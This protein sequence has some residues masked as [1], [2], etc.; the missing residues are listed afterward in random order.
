MSYVIK[1]EGTTRIMATEYSGVN[2][3]VADA[4]DMALRTNTEVT[5]YELVPIK[6]FVRSDKLNV[7]EFKENET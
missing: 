6:S 2:A 7:K 5:I 4:K 3:A 1:D